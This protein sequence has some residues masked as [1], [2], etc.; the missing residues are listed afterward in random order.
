MTVEDRRWGWLVAAGGVAF[1]AG[2]FLPWISMGSGAITLTL[3]GMQLNGMQGIFA[4]HGVIVIVGGVILAALGLLIAAGVEA[5]IPA[6]IA[7]GLGV[8]WSVWEIANV[9]GGQDR[10]TGGAVVTIGIGIFLMLAGAGAALA[11]VL[12][13]EI[14]HAAA[15]SA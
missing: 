15:K 7:A 8:G 5:R 11:G 14:N 2:A 4:N 10:L 13:P 9:N 3:T 12:I 6:L 1:S